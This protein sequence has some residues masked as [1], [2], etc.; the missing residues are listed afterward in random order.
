[1]ISVE[2]AEQWRV[3]SEEIRAEADALRAEAETKNDWEAVI[4]L[5]DAARHLWSAFGWIAHQ[6]AKGELSR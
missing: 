2:R 3:K 5:E 6:H 1:M 4:A